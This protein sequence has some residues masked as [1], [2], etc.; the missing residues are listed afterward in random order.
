MSFWTDAQLFYWG[1]VLLDGLFKNDPALVTTKGLPRLL[2]AGKIWDY[3]HSV[4][5]VGN[6]EHDAFC[7]VSAARAEIR[8]LWEEVADAYRRYKTKEEPIEASLPGNFVLEI[9][10]FRPG[11]DVFDY[12]VE[13]CQSDGLVAILRGPKLSLLLEATGELLVEYGGRRYT[14]S[15]PRRLAE[16]LKAGEVEARLNPWFAARVMVDNN[17]VDDVW[18]GEEL[19]G[20]YKAL[21]EF[22]LEQYKEATKMGW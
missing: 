14:E 15:L 18:V 21:K 7:Q 12:Y 10:N 5:E 13:D 11:A 4:G 8:W 17:V 1:E 6:S 22:M 2:S 9:H 16:L 20:S 3:L 19:P